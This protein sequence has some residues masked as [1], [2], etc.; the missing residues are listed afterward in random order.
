MES[1]WWWLIAAALFGIAE[2]TTPG[3]VF[4]WLAGAA[5]VTGILAMLLGLPLTFEFVL[6]GLLAFAFVYA[7]RRF[8]DR[9]PV[10]SSDP[11]LNDR[12]SRLIGTTV[13]VVEAIEGGRGRVRV[14]DGVW[15]ARGPDAAEG[16]RMRVAGAD[17]NCLLVEPLASPAAPELPAR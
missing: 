5:A 10:P 15:S 7:G 11:R 8:Y 4:A 12:T 9:N 16:A 3:V 1:H 14:G 13:I 2:L 6:F 17:G